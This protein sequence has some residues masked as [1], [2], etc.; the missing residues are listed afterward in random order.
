MPRKEKE[1]CRA[2]E[3]EISRPESHL[4]VIYEFAAGWEDESYR[5]CKN[6]YR[7][8]QVIEDSYNASC[9]DARDRY[10]ESLEK[11]LGSWRR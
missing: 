11:F 10:K 2:C 3:V 5:L 9:E 6:C 8:Y 7:I 4:M 1:T